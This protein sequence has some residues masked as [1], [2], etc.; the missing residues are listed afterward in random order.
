MGAGFVVSVSAPSAFALKLAQRAGMVVAA[1]APGG[2]MFFDRMGPIMD[3]S[4]I[5]RMANQI[6]E[7]HKPYPHDEAVAGI[8]EHIRLFWEPRMRKALTKVLDAGGG[9]LDTLA[10]EGANSALG[11]VH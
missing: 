7:F 3:D 6:A 10:I 1:L 4:D 5:V 2:M 8:A 11:R 9:S